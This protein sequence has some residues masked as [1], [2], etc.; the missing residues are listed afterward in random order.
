V[1]AFPP[2]SSRYGPAQPTDELTELLGW[3][4][5]AAREVDPSMVW[6]RMFDQGRAPLVIAARMIFVV[7]ARKLTKASYPEI[8]ATVGNVNHSTVLT[9]ERRYKRGGGSAKVRE[10]IQAIEAALE[11]VRRPGSER[12]HPQLG[13]NVEMQRK[14]LESLALRPARGEEVRDG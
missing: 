12:L 14:L 5:L 2:R 13:G 7:Q 6:G 11:R 4:V 3:V 9:A 10:K 8:A 1:I